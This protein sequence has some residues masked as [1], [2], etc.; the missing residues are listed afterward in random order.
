MH[1]YGSWSRLFFYFFSDTHVH[2]RYTEAI[3]TA[4]GPLDSVWQAS[5]MEGLATI[6]ILDAW[7][8]NQVCFLL[9]HVKS[10]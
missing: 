1:R 4:K 7:S 5:A 2:F 8:S 6:P 3:A 9:L 10:V